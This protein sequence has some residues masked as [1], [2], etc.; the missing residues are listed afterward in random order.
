MWFA[1]RV[2]PAAEREAWLWAAALV[3]V[4]PLVVLLQQ[5]NLA[6][7]GAAALDD[8][9]AV[10]LAAASRWWGAFL[11]GLVVVCMGQIHMSG[12][13]FAAGFALWALLF[14]RR[15]VAWTGWLA[16]SAVGALP[17]LPWLWALASA[18]GGQSLAHDHWL[19]AL[20]FKYWIRWVQEPL[21]F[22]ADYTLQ[23]DFGDFLTYPHIL[24]RPTYL[25]AGLH[26][27]LGIVGLALLGRAARSL[28]TG[29]RELGRRFTGTDSP[30][31]FTQNA[32]LWGYG[33]VLTASCCSLH[34]HYMAILFPLEFL[35]LARLALGRR[36]APP[37]AVRWGRVSLAVLW[38]VQLLLSIQLLDYIHVRQRING[39]YGPTYASQQATCRR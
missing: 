36:D 5:Q 18:H 14:D 1:Y 22:G 9:G 6:A 39:E 19:H 11:W 15:G 2:A 24:G 32:A 30:G 8:A 10:R 33:L 3:A 20:E 16:G 28:W 23:D 17:M 35:W 37:S 21:G 13:F 29:R 4:N 38:T 26:L 12:F 27:V 7:V 31:A 34:R 25:V